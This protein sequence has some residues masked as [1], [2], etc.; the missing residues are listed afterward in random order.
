LVEVDS[1]STQTVEQEIQ[2]MTAVGRAMQGLDERTIHRVLT[3]A[4]DRYVTKRRPS[5][6][7][8]DTDATTGVEDVATLYDLTNPQT[9]AERALVVGFWYQEL[10]RQSDF[11]AQQVNHELKQLGHGVE[12]ITAAFNDLINRTPRFAMQTR[13]SGSTKQARKR[14]RLTTEGVRRV[15]SLLAGDTEEEGRGHR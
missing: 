8:P 4:T 11:D 15:R 14:Y 1:G 13:K 2:A 5:P 7:Q 10:Q 12:N 3:W 9:H 6:N